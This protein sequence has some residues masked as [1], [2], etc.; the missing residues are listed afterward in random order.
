VSE[1]DFRLAIATVSV[2]HIVLE[3]ILASDYL[4]TLASSEV[5]SRLDRLSS[6]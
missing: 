6:R 3:A 1:L 2:R 4:P 5:R